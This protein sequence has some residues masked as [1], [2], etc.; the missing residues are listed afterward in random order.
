[1]A[2]AIKLTAEVARDLTKLKFSG[3]LAYVAEPTDSEI[4]AEMLRRRR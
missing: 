4:E 2:E 3:L 1:M